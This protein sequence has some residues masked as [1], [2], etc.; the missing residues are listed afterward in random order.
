VLIRLHH[1]INHGN[2]C[3]NEVCGCRA[4]QEPGKN[5]GQPSPEHWTDAA[6]HDTK[7]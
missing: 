7:P 4:S 2:N 5:A 1:S 6:L 3:S